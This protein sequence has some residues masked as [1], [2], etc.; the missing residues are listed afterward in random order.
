MVCGESMKPLIL[1]GWP[2]YQFEEEN[3]GSK[4]S[5][6]IILPGESCRRWP[7]LQPILAL[8]HPI[9]AL[10]KVTTGRILQAVGN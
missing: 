6:S 7:N 9:M 2:I 1:T 5:F 3:L 4:L 8:G 10:T